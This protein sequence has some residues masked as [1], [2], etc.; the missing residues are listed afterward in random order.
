VKWFKDNN[1]KEGKG[2]YQTVA[3]WFCLAHINQRGFWH[4]EIAAEVAH[5]F[6]WSI[7]NLNCSAHGRRGCVSCEHAIDPKIYS[8]YHS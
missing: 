8:N 1:S 6:K 4:C 3:P 7:K 5:I 2:R